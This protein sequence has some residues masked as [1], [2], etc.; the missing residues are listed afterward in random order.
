MYREDVKV[1]RIRIEYFGVAIIIL[2]FF[3]FLIPIYLASEAAGLQGVPIN[4]TPK[5]EGVYYLRGDLTSTSND[6][7]FDGSVV[8]E[9]LITVNFDEVKIMSEFYKSP[10]QGIILEG[11]LVNSDDELYFNV[12]QFDEKNNMLEFYQKDI[13]PQTFS[14][15]IITEKSVSDADSSEHKSIGGAPISMKISAKRTNIGQ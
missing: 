7:S 1:A 12:G 2:L 11:W 9:Y 14:L 10:S 3:I 6:K 5:I 15:F 8:G 4:P 13:E